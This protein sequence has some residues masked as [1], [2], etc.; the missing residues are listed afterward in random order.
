MYLFGDKIAPISVDYNATSPMDVPLI[1]LFEWIFLETFVANK[2][3]EIYK[4]RKKTYELNRLFQNTW[5][6]SKLYWAK[7]VLGFNGKII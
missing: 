4:K 1:V 5:A 3:I 6:M 2:N 7:F